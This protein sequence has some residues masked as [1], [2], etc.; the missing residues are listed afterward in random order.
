MGPLNTTE[1]PAL[2]GLQMDGTE[3]TPVCQGGPTTF[4][5][6]QDEP[7]NWSCP[8]GSQST[9][10]QPVVIGLVTND[11][12]NASTG[13]VDHDLSVADQKEMA[14]RP[15]LVVPH[16]VT[17]QSVFLGLYVEIS[18]SVYNISYVDVVM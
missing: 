6:G 7:V 12:G 16:N 3:N 5:A 18:P 9:Y 2:L 17:E 15:V 10:E 8:V 11:R 4:L 1:Q 14:D 13:P